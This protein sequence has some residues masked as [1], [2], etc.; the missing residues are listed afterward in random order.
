[1]NNFH[2]LSRNKRNFF[3]LP[4]SFLHRTFYTMIFIFLS[5]FIDSIRF[6]QYFS[7]HFLLLDTLIPQNEIFALL[8]NLIENQYG[9]KYVHLARVSIVFRS[10][11]FYTYY[12]FSC[13]N[14]KHKII[15][16]KVEV[17]TLIG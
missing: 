14:A 16:F 11:S 6:W 10:I 4:I 1:M 17:R 8:L 5:L 15:D 12:S 3:L 7:V 2:A 13:Y 9:L